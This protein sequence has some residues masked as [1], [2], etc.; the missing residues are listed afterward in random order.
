MPARFRMSAG[1]LGIV[2]WT[3][4]MLSLA[5]PAQA[6]DPGGPASA[7]R[8]A[9]SVIDSTTFAGYQA[10]FS[11]A[12]ATAS[13]RFRVPALSCTSAYRGTA[14]VAGVN[15]GVLYSSAFLFT[16][17]RHGKA[18]YFAAVV[19]NGNETNYPRTPFHAGNLIQVSTKVT[20]G[21]PRSPSPTSRWASPRSAA[22][23]PPRLRSAPT[24]ATANWSRTDGNCVFPTSAP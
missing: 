19:I 5:T 18:K 1:T 8:L 10:D 12:S 15:V 13:A 20:P 6:G 2:A 22:G 24:W 3:A 17:C 4:P 14:P 7:T 9:Q 16:A 23:R 11:P 21:E